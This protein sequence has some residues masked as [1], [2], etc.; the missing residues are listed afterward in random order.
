MELTTLKLLIKAHTSDDNVDCQRAKNDVILGLT[1]FILV[2]L[3]V[4]A[5]L[6]TVVI[7]FCLIS[8]REIIILTITAS[9][10]DINMTSQHY[11]ERKSCTFSASI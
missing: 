1:F 4:V 10:A 3:E 7:Q 9:L 6:Y 5:T 11:L 2:L 8:K